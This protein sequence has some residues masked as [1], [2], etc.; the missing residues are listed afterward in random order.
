MQRSLVN[1]FMRPL[2]AVCNSLPAAVNYI[3]DCTYH[4]RKLCDSCIRQG[5]KLKPKPPAWFKSGYRKKTSCEKCGYIAKF[6]DKQL[7]VY[8][9]D[10]NLKNT[11]SINLKSVCLNCRVEIANSI[12][13]WRESPIIP[14]F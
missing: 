1:S 4:Y 7:T 14:D 6:P 3:K 9:V 13:P 8:H 12:L 2:C 5:K 11:A 10:G